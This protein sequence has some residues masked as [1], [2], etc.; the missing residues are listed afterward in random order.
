MNE[1]LITKTILARK[2]RRLLGQSA[3]PEFAGLILLSISGKYAARGIERTEE[4][5]QRVEDGTET[6]RKEKR[7]NGNKKEKRDTKL[8][9]AGA[10]ERS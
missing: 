3:F 9:A 1:N 6:E 10:H 5:S 8:L 4:E 7:E 2:I